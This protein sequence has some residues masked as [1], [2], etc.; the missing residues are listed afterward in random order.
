MTALK[1]FQRL[2]C[3]GIW[4]ATEDAQRRDVI[5]SL[6]DATLVIFDQ[7]GTALSHWSLPAI[8]RLNAG[9]RPAVFR[10]GPDAEELL[11][12]DDDVMIRGITRVRTAIERHHPHPGRLRFFLLAGGVVFGLALTTLWLP[13]AMIDYAASVLPQ[14]KRSA[15]GQALLVNIRRVSGKPCNT[16]AGQIALERMR[17]RLVGDVPGRLVVVS[18]GVV[19]S[20][21][22]PGGIILLNRAL[23]E[24]H[25]A[26][27]VA[28]GYIL[29]E[30][31]RARQTDPIVELLHDAGL[32]SAFRLLTTGN[33]PA[34]SLESYTEALL[35]A[36]DLPVDL[37]HALEAFSAASIPTSPY[38]F[39]VDISG[40]TTVELIEA[41]RLS[42]AAAKPVLSDGDWVALQGICGE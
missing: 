21:H 2:E 12:L 29:V 22:L 3:A 34:K 26:P 30:D 23:I 14:A 4:R 17:K 35:I 13:G 32:L 41:D 36:E 31:L 6:G 37:E 16:P 8:E 18:G 38:A 42:P 1:D 39:A 40:E 7:K 24:D 25:E 10:P 19:Q 5:V 27:E 11:E 20:R 33:I 28:A 9:T 15:I